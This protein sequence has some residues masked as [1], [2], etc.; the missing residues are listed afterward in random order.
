MIKSIINLR[1]Q[2]GDKF[3]LTKKNGIGLIK[4]ILIITFVIGLIS[5]IS[6]KDIMIPSG[7][8]LMLKILNSILAVKQWCG[9]MIRLEYIIIFQFREDSVELFLSTHLKVELENYFWQKMKRLKFPLE[10][11]QIQE[12]KSS[13]PLMMIL[14]D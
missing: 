2:F 11:H 7:K 5:I 12:C 9:P 13:K 4:I 1:D 6:I 10:E 8:N 3:H 14:K